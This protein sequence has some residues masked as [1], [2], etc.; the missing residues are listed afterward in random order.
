M[1]LDPF[2]R[3]QYEDNKF[4][5]LKA[6][7]EAIQSGFENVTKLDG[8]FEMAKLTDCSLEL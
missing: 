3:S 1:L 8:R 6:L 4:D 2:I 7:R 5:D